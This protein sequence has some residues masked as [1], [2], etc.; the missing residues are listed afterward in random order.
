MKINIEEIESKTLHNRAADYIDLLPKKQ[1][2]VAKLRLLD[3]LSPAQIAKELK[4][5]TNYVK[6]TLRRSLRRLE[7]L[8]ATHSL[9][10]EKGAER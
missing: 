3:G 8:I 4:T 7:E 9:S 1:R 2:E 5:D 10:E 6:V